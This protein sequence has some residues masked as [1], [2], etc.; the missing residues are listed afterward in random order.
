MEASPAT[1]FGSWNQAAWAEGERQAWPPAVRAWPGLAVGTLGLE[2][3]TSA[4]PSSPLVQSL[5]LLSRKL[6]GMKEVVSVLGMRAG[7]Q[8]PGV[9]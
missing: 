6:A 7:T 1:F 2:E 8:I 3:D 5:S 4:N 9:Q